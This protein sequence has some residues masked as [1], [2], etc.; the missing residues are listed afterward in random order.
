MFLSLKVFPDYYGDSSC[1]TRTII[2]EVH[3]ISR[4]M[5]SRSAELPKEVPVFGVGLSEYDTHHRIY[6]LSTSQD[7]LLLSADARF[8]CSYASFL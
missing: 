5:E 6:P 2:S 1:I 7:D 4:R 3:F 8:A